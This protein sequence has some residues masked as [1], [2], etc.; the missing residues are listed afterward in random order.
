MA[1]EQSMV[2]R[3]LERGGRFSQFDIVDAAM[4]LIAYQLH[5]MAEFF[6]GGNLIRPW[7][8][9]FATALAVYFLRARLPEG[10]APLLHVMST[11]RHLSS[12]AEDVTWKPYPAAPNTRE[13]S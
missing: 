9:L 8:T 3:Q 2:F 13:E 6:L 5:Y 11:P 12:M 10:V 4:V 7:V 1:L